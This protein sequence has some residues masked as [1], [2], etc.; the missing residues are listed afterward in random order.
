[1]NMT[2][3]RVAIVVA[4]ML[5]SSMALADAAVR[6]GPGVQI[7]PEGSAPTTGLISGRAL[8]WVDSGDSNKLKFRNP[9]GST[10]TLDGSGGGS[11]YNQTIQD[12]GSNLTQRAI[13]NFAGSGVSCADDTTKT[14]CTISGGGGTT[15]T[16]DV[17]NAT[18]ATG[19]QITAAVANS[20]TNVG[21][22]FNNSTTLNGSTKLFSFR[23]NTTEVLGLSWNGNDDATLTG[24]GTYD[25]TIRAGGS[26]NL[27]LGSQ[28]GSL[29]LPI[30]D[31]TQRFGWTTA[32]LVS[33]HAHA[34]M[35]KR[36][37][38]LT[39]AATITPTT[40]FHH[41]TGGTTIDTIAATNFADNGLLTLAADG[42]TITVS[43]SG[44][45]KSAFTIAQDTMRVLMWDATDSKWYPQN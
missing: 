19:K 18:A 7:R 13:L 26:G 12:E 16:I 42:G 25:F 10:V 27:R 14:T 41:V 38:Q 21:F 15:Q 36:G 30:A 35:M 8:L 6:V 33:V 34:F 43:A 40:G 31:G 45:S 28:N 4:T 32:Y 29:I 3:T 37:A 39:A 44:N 23:N 5:A 11:S 9:A 2:K 20:S 22:I 24:T 17:I 1:M